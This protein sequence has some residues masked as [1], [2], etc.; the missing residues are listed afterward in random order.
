MKKYIV[1]I[2]LL[3]CFNL[4]AQ[5]NNPCLKEVLDLEKQTGTDLN[6]STLEKKNV[7]LSYTVKVTD[8]DDESTISNVKIYKMGD[9]MRFFSDQVNMYTSDKEII[10]ELPQQ[11]VIVINSS[12]KEFKYQK[13][14]D[15]MQE[16][17]R[18][19]LDSCQVAKCESIGNNVKVLVLKVNPNQLLDTQISEMR[20]EYNTELKRVLSVKTTYQPDYK[21]KTMWMIYREFDAEST[22]KFSSFRNQFLDKRGNLNEKFK[23]YELVDNRDKKTSKSK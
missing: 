12:M 8:W 23:D 13:S 14:R 21:L 22:Y 2:S 19:F 1:V 11:K 20:Y 7:Y 16:L 5:E 18:N 3:A 4:F 17:R 9:E 10:V 15:E 6:D